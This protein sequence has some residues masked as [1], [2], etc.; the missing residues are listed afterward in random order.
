MFQTNQ[1]RASRPPVSLR[2]HFAPS[3]LND[4][5]AVFAAENMSGGGVAGCTA[6]T[7][8]SVKLITPSGETGSIYPCFEHNTMADLNFTWRY[9]APNAGSIWTAPNAIQHICISSGAGGSRTGTAW[10]QN[11]DLKPADVLTDI[12]NGQLRS[13]SWVIPTGANSDHA[14]GNDGGGP[15]W[16]AAIVNAIGSST[17]CDS[18]P[19]IGEYRDIHHV[20]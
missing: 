18:I 1:G 9:Y 12:A 13:V 11:V 4:A 2:R 6:P 14:I 7:T 5:Q 15:S 3:A 20:G 10:T 19:H 8:T 17:S 16:V